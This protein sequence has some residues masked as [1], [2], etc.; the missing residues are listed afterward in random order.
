M[1]TRHARNLFLCTVSALLLPTLL[2]SA[3]APSPI[4]QTIVAIPYDFFAPDVKN[5]EEDIGSITTAVKDRLKKEGFIKGS[6]QLAS[7]LPIASK[8]TS[9]GKKMAESLPGSGNVIKKLALEHKLDEGA[10][11]FLI[12]CAVKPIV[13]TYAATLLNSLEG[14]PCIAF[15]NQDPLQNERYLSSLDMQKLDLR[16]KATKHII[17]ADLSRLKDNNDRPF[18][19]RPRLDGLY[20]AFRAYPHL[21]FAKA[22]RGA[23]DSVC[24]TAQLVVFDTNQTALETL[25]QHKIDRLQT[26]H[27]QNPE[28]IVNQVSAALKVPERK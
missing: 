1:D 7:L 14:T 23:A 11:D 2:V 20:T 18:Y 3:A 28:D 6:K 27:C 22:L 4:P 5:T 26:V 12:D 10:I 9:E 25:R 17:V 8:L 21:A 13:T 16:N 24:T 19:E 15:G